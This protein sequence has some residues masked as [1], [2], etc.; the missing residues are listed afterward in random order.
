MHEYH[1]SDPKRPPDQ[2]DKRML[3]FLPNDAIEAWL[4]APVEHS[5]DYV[6]QFPAEQLVATPEPVAPAAKKVK[7]V[8]AVRDKTDSAKDQGDLLA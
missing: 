6:R 7:A 1:R 4:D 8:R 2:Q 3:V 5:M